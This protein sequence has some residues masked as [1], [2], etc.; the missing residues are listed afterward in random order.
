MRDGKPLNIFTTLAHHPRL[1]K[2]FNLLGGLFLNTGLLPA[3]V[4]EIV[5]LRMAWRTGCVYEFG[6]HTEIGRGVG[7]VADEIG[8]L[9]EPGLEGWPANDRIV[10][11]MVDELYASDCLR[12]KTAAQLLLSWGAACLIELIMLAGF[13]R[14]LAGVLNSIAVEREPGVPGWPQ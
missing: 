3:R 14:M 13:Y 4:R 12:D 2:R 1:L 8:R 11:V 9:A 6:Q 7:L 5:V 10:V